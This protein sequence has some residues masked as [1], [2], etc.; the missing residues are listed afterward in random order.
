[1]HTNVVKGDLERALARVATLRDEVRLHLHL[2]SMDLKKE[3]DEKL[4]PR[5][6]EVE[7]GAKD[8][9]QD[10]VTKLEDFLARLEQRR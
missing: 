1:M 7:A 10:L 9:A 8:K 3:W 6:F 4:S 5:I 2:A